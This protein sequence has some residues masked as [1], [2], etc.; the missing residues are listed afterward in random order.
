MTPE[1]HAKIIEL[2]PTEWSADIPNKH[3]PFFGE[4]AFEWLVFVV[5]WTVIAGVHY[6]LH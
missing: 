2:K 3:E 4:R 1:E 6:I 5:A